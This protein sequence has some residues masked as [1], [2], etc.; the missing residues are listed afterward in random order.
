MRPRPCL[1]TT[2]AICGSG[3]NMPAPISQC[4]G[5]QSFLDP[6]GLLERSFAFSALP[7]GSQRL[8]LLEDLSL[9]R[10]LRLVWAV[11]A[12]D[13]LW[14]GGVARKFAINGYRQW[15]ASTIRPTSLALEPLAPSR[16]KNS[17]ALPLRRW[18]C[19][20]HRAKLGA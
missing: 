20:S 10:Q 2:S 11:K 18:P 6:F 8:D 9:R 14:P 17:D 16:P 13:T 7:G 1:A 15:H 3:F 19:S 12:T 5:L 4:H